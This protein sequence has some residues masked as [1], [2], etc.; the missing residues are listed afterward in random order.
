VDPGSST[1]ARG[2]YDSALFEKFAELEPNSWWFRS[3]NRLIEHTVRA[4]FPAARRVLEVGCGTGYTMLALL[5]ALPDAGLTGT[6]LYEEGLAIARRRLP[7]VSF[8][9]LDVLTMDQ[10]GA[11]DLVGAFDVLEH[12]G[13]DAG[14]LRALHAAIVPGGGLVLTVPQ[15]PALWSEAD[16]YAYHERRYRRFELVQRLEAAGFVVERVT[17]FVTLLAPLMVAS[18]LRERFGAP[19]DPLREFAIPQRLDRAFDA[20]ARVEQRLL[21]H[22][23]SLPFGGSLL[24]VARRP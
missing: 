8:E 24:A 14:A 6:E 9:Q 22:G 20:V 11:Y 10:R 15:H 4:H 21:A 17:S 12:I 7:D 2:G 3:R 13:D 19:F 5:A 23:A 1:A 18:R 16:V